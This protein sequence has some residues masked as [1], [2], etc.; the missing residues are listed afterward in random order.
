MIFSIGQDICRAVSEEERKLPKHI[1]LCATVRH[2]FQSK[3]L[4][5]ILY[6]LG[7]FENCRFG[8][9]IE[10]AQTKAIDT[11]LTY[12]TP[13]IVTGDGNVFFH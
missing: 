3:Q 11:V 12:L 4:T 8:L 6:R 5:N 10:T 1:L 7:H 9:N 13:Q 2:L